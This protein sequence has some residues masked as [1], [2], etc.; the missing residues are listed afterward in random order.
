MTKK[1]DN[2]ANVAFDRVRIISPLLSLRTDTPAEK[3]LFRL[4]AK[5]LAE[6]NHKSERTIINWVKAY[7]AEQGYHGLLPKYP[8]ERSDCRLPPQFESVLARAIEI[9]R[10]CPTL[11]VN[12]IIDCLESEQPNLC[13]LIKRGTL[14]RYLQKN[15]CSRREMVNHERY[16]GRQV[17]GRFQ[18]RQANDLWQGDVKESPKSGIIDEQG[19]PTRLFIHYFIDDRSRYITDYEISSIQDTVQVLTSL[20]RGVAR[21]GAPHVLL[22]DNGSPYK[23]HMVSSV[24]RQL[25]IKTTYHRA[26]A[27][28]CKGKIERNNGLGFSKLNDQIS[29]R[30]PMTVQVYI[31]AVEQIIHEHNTT[32]SPVIDNKTPE[33]VYFSEQIQRRMID[34]ELLALA[35]KEPCRRTIAKDGTVS[36]DGRS[37]RANLEHT[38][39]GEVVSLLVS[40]S[41]GGATVEQLL[42]DGSCIT[43]EQL[44][45]G[46]EVDRSVYKVAEQFPVDENAPN[47]YVERL[48]RASECRMKQQSSEPDPSRDSGPDRNPPTDT[49]PAPDGT[50]EQ[51]EPWQPGSAASSPYLRLAKSQHK[52]R[53]QS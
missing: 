10:Q 34:P 3:H 7:H 5:Q 29:V 32:P 33:E 30:K 19:N 40:R 28:W 24:C 2:K 35:F 47:P 23:N 36:V 49:T 11:S 9:R 44:Q 1:I 31:R 41:T 53:E 43:L 20:R 21:Y 52:T 38:A 25:N 48:L 22:M 45:I 8:T 46:P 15:H 37:Y 6:L 50:K 17:F 16:K 39:V 42:E 4:R 12:D 51:S 26:K 13:G 14:Q 18:A 27:A